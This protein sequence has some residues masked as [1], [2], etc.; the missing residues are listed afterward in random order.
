MD[1]TNKFV[2][3]AF[4]HHGDEEF[5]GEGSFG[6]V[7]KFS[8]KG[9]V[10][11]VKKVPNTDMDIRQEKELLEMVDHGFIIKYHASYREGRL[12]CIEMEYADKG[13]MTSCLQKQAKRP[14]ANQFKEYNVWRTLWHLSSAL[15]YLHTLPSP[16]MHRSAQ[17]NM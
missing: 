4:K 10:F 6:N 5:I 14:D 12:F 13:T 8:K 3:E 9:K 2:I 15:D 17:H 7:Y 16:V 11:A 1:H